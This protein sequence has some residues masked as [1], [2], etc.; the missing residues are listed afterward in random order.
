MKKHYSTKLN[1]DVL[2]IQGLELTKLG[3]ER[4]SDKQ[5]L[6]FLVVNFTHQ[7]I[8][9]IEV[10]KWLGQIQGKPEN[11]IDK[12]REQQELIRAILEDWFGADLKGN[13]RYASALFCQAMEDVLKDCHNCSQFIAT[14]SDQISAILE[15][16]E[17]KSVLQRYPED[18]KTLSKY[19]LFSAPKVSLP[20]KGNMVSE[21]H[22][23]IQE[24][25]SAENIRVWCF[26]TPQQRLIFN[27]AKL[28][29]LAPW[30]SGKTIFMVAESIKLADKGEKVL[31]LFFARGD[32]ISTTKK[33]L[34]AMDLEL[35]F[36]EYGDLIKIE[37]VLFKDG[38]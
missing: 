20:V 33:S 22:K 34:L 4:G 12:A 18:F 29:L 21:V 10:K 24:A 19:L 27:S 3:G 36:Q 38:A 9:N 31:F 5:E 13:W 2:V 26:P 17:T 7:Y 15:S 11:I 35:K 28:I 30:G 16:L 14:N 25:G 32:S 1:E 23:A 37:T 8:L 6:D